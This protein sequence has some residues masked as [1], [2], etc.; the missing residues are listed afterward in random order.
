MKKN[1]NKWERFAFWYAVVMTLGFYLALPYIFDNITPKEL[2]K[3][4]YSEER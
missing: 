4:V 2:I 3:Y 1:L